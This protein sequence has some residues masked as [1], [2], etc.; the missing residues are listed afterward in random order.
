MPGKWRLGSVLFGIVAVMLVVCVGSAAAAAGP[1][2]EALPERDSLVREENPLSNGGQ[3]TALAWAAD[4]PPAGVTSISPGGWHPAGSP[5]AAGAYWGTS[6]AEPAAAVAQVADL[7]SAEGQYQALWLDMSAPGSTK[8]GY[9]L[10][11]TY[12]TATSCT[13]TLSKWSAGTRTEFLSIVEPMSKG[14]L[15]G[16]ADEGSKV[17]AWVGAEGALGRNVTAT[18]STYSG[19]YA[20]IEASGSGTR[21]GHFRVGPLIK[22]SRVEEIAALTPRD[23]LNRNEAPLS[24]SGKWAALQWAGDV[25]ATGIDTN[26]G[27]HPNNG[28][29]A[30]AGA[31]LTTSFEQPAAASV[32]MA[33][34][35]AVAG[36]R[37][38]LWLDM[39]SPG[40]EQS[41]YQLTWTYET[42]SF[43]VVE[44]SKWS[45]GTKTKLGSIRAPIVESSTLAISDEGS[46]VR[47]W[48]GLEGSY[49]SVM[50]IEDSTYS[51]GYAGI[52]G[53]GNAGLL[54]EFK[55]G[56][57]V[58]VSPG[59]EVA[60]L[61]LRDSLNRIE[62]PLS[63][64]GRWAGLQWSGDVPAT[65]IDQVT[66]WR[67]NSGYP[68]LSGAYWN[69]S[70][71]QPAAASVTMS[72]S[73]AVE[74]RHQALWL[75]MSTPGAKQSGY[76][77]SWTYKSS[78]SYTVALSKWSSGIQTELAST[79]TTIS[80]GSTL[81]IADE[82]STVKAWLGV[83]GSFTQILSK[84]DSTYAAGYPG[85]QGSGTNGR[86]TE[87][88]AGPLVKSTR[89]VE[90]AETTLR[91]PL[92]R[93]ENPLSNGG[94]WAALQWSADSPATGVDSTTGWHPASTSAVSG[95]YWSTSFSQAVAASAVMPNNL[96]PGKY[97]AL[98]LDMPAPGTT[99]SG[100]ELRW[101]CINPPE[102]TVAL[103]KWS[104][105]V[106][107]VLGSTVLMIAKGSTVAISDEG[108]TLHAWTG[109]GGSLAP[110]LAV[111]D[112][113]YSSG[114]TGMQA[115]GTNGG[116]TLVLSEF[117]AGS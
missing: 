68:V 86:L 63:N 94:Q 15:M 82:G 102:Y 31:Y 27:W 107:T 110:V 99:Q 109:S 1:E 98:W 95:A 3:W 16:I 105:G 2:L 113:T 106:Q 117:R 79:A 56:P 48:L 23:P 58:A 18:D 114:Y 6:F 116:N 64:A 77:L 55:A 62:N 41:G 100:Y 46:T 84:A 28:F 91:D 22:A 97:R 101:T 19:G 59:E 26:A 5:A 14:S 74:G 43:Y 60:D 73:T 89:A 61:T 53:S 57:L 9:E 21:L 35:T 8:S 71:A 96:T 40:T 36:R 10:R 52:E 20:G 65:G 69:T 81:A 72:A 37:Q 25:P 50:S 38:A 85:L 51:G 34:S 42:A 32:V 17:S 92:N 112:S 66:G 104:E 7:P 70:F 87:F 103:S 45:G 24:N 33:A 88:K 47:A 11:C 49:G 115:L 93:N 54:G 44:L 30:V 108:S 78:T 90:V 76:E 67:P 4:S 29:P 80:A 12:K 83:G 13:V 75:D 111:E 39:P